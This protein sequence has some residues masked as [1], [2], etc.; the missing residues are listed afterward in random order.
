MKHERESHVQILKALLFDCR[1]SDRDIAKQVGTSQPTVTRVRQR[2]ISG[3]VIKS[4]EII[5]DLAK[6]G[7]EIFAFSTMP[8]PVTDVIKEDSKVVY[9]VAMGPNKMFTISVH[10]NY[11]DYH[12][13]YH[14]YS[15]ESSY[16]VPTS[17]K[18]MKSLSFKNISL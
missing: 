7:F 13:F 9:A 16:L 14:K 1:R 18:P 10:K 5:L 11:T 3:G 4:Y 17:T 8:H 2:F 6:L 15:V 12:G